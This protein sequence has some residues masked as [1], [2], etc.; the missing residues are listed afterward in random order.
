[1][2]LSMVCSVVRI[3]FGQS[4]RIVMTRK[5]LKNEKRENEIGKRKND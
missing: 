2:T 3:I 4:A 1:M 5:H